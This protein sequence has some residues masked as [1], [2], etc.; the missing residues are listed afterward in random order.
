MRAADGSMLSELPIAKG[1]AV[2]LHLQ[3]SNT[4][5]ELWG[6][7]AHEWKPERWLDPLPSVL[8]EAHVPGVY[9]SL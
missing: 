2:V 6:E 8:E 3:G 9:H 1:T 4:N 7:D 5:Q